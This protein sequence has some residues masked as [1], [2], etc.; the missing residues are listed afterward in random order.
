MTDPIADMLTRIRNSHLARAKSVVMPYSSVK[1][2]IANKLAD[3]GYVGKIEREGVGKDQSIKIELLYKE[4]Q[5]VINKIKRVSRPGR[6]VY[7]T[8]K[9]IKPILSGYGASIVSTS[10]GIM[11]DKEARKAGLGGEVICQVW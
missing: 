11:S 10:S 5:A 1:F 9:E 2:A 3:L 7:Q 4:D 6:R 8:K